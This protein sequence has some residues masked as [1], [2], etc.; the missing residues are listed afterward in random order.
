MIAKHFRSNFSI[1]TTLFWV[2]LIFILNAQVNGSAHI[3]FDTSLSGQ[4]IKFI[5]ASEF[6]E[7]TSLFLVISLISFSSYLFNNSYII[8]QYRSFLP[9]FIA[10]ILLGSGNF[11][12]TLDSAHFGLLFILLTL[13]SLLN[14]ENA[15]KPQNNITN[16]SLLLSAGSLLDPHLLYFIPL[17][18]I[19]AI[20]FKRL[21]LR[22]FFAS[23][24]GIITPYIIATSIFYLRDTLDYQLILFADQ[25][26][27]FKWS[28]PSVH[29]GF[30]VFLAFIGIVSLITLASL[31]KKTDRLKTHSRHVITVVLLFLL[32]TIAY[33][34]FGLITLKSAFIYWSFPLSILFSIHLN[35][36]RP[37]TSN[38]SIILLLIVSL[39]GFI[40]EF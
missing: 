33:F 18:W 32:L 2:I 34:S 35:N 25:F 28:V 36:I 26:T 1:L 17:I 20:I 21:N 7:M 8:D 40:A 12:L 23:L 3:D 19:T 6:G 22:A 31:Q 16:A 24:I 38:V 37:K 9:M 13:L 5:E 27:A 10:V 11:M 29:Q 39:I 4:F 30:L 15:V 14:M